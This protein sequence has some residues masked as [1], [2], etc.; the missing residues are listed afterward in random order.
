VDSAKL[1]KAG[2]SV[3][4]ELDPLI[5]QLKIEA[6]PLLVIEIKGPLLLELCHNIINLCER[7]KQ[8]ST[9]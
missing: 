1:Y 7:I 2:E 9:T 8:Y 4:A 5:I 6:E 3:S